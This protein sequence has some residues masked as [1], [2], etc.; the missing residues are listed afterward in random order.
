MHK[1]STFVHM[2][3]G[4]IIGSDGDRIIGTSQFTIHNSFSG[5]LSFGASHYGISLDETAVSHFERF[6]EMLASWN[7][8]M[9]L[10]SA[11][12]IKRFVEYHLLDSLKAAS[13]YDFSKVRTLLDF[14]TGAGLPGIPIALAYPN[15]HVTLVDSR[16]KRSIFLEEVLKEFPFLHA[17]VIRSRVENLP[18]RYNVTFDA[19]ITRA[20]VKLKKYFLLSSRFISKNGALIAI[21]GDDIEDELHDLFSTVDL[22]FFN[23]SSMVPAEVE[24]V[25]RGAVVV[26]THI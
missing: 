8:R 25:R 2:E 18:S 15:I 17:E 6:A 4:N 1:F 24:N 11:R 5:V 23:I 26:I 12:D 3:R 19:V 9:N 21:K 10:I 7:S 13:C 20:T 14:G 16:L 22:Q